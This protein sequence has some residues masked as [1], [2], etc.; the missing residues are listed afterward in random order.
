[1]LLRNANIWGREGRW[2]IRIADTRIAEV[3][4]GLA[5]AAGDGAVEDG[6]VED[7]DGA[8]VI[9]GL[10]DAH[11]H[12]DKTLWSGDWVPHTPAPDLVARVTHEEENRHRY[13]VPSVDNSTALL[14]EMAASG[15]TRIRTHTDVDPGVGLRGV[16]NVA[17]AAR[18]LDGRIAVEQVAFP[19]RGMLR[20]P[21]TQELLEEAVRSGAV[22]A[23]GGIDPAGLDNDPVRHLDVIFGIAE[24]HGAKLDIHLH[25]GGSLGAWEFRQIIERTKALGLQGRV[26]ISH[27]FALSDAVE[28]RRPALV[29]ELVAGLAANGISLTTVAPSRGQ[30][31][32]KAMRAAGGVVGAG[33]D[34]VRDLWSPFGDGRMLDRAMM[35][36]H[37]LGGRLDE[38]LEL[39]LHTATFGGARVLG[40]GDGEF[41]VVEG[42]VADLV[43]LP[44][45]N[46]AEAVVSRPVPSLVVAG[47]R[48]GARHGALV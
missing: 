43:A 46:A 25:D 19:Q 41:G 15:T 18:N 44:V 13:G 7:L 9:P 11:C 40:L 4:R 32:I 16:E 20:K 23:V 38:D 5:A 26:T 47:G 2:D 10:V 29:E 31:P 37:A 17:Q 48:V 45:R 6:A 36:A 33:N 39:A 24:R 30:L 34:G 28:E 21:G 3:G 27:A 35:L 42:A 1:M 12:V 22:Q 8:L 14:R